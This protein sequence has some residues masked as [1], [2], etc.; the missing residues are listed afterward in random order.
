[1]EEH[2]KKSRVVYG[3]FSK[4]DGAGFKS[5]LYNPASLSLW[6]HDG[7]VVS[8]QFSYVICRYLQYPLH[9][10]RKRFALGI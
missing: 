3:L 6:S 8:G 9:V 4:L 10:D 2:I 7:T 1:M 5:Q